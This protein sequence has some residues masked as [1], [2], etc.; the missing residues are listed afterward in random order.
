[1]EEYAEYPEDTYV[2]VSGESIETSPAYRI[3]VHLSAVQVNISKPGEY[4]GDAAS[5]PSISV[6]RLL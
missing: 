3:S 6:A 5:E 1:M 4:G 2:P